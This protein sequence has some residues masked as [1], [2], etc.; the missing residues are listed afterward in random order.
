MKVV[1]AGN[2]ILSYTAALSLITEDKSVEVSIIGPRDN[3]GCASLAAAAMFNSFCEVD[4][5]TFSNR[6]DKEK[7]L[8]N[9]RAAPLWVEYIKRLEELSHVKI[10]HGFGTFLINN[11][12]TDELEDRNFDAILGALSEF[13]EPHEMVKLNSVENYRPMPNDRGSRA[14]YIPREGWVNPIDLMNSLKIILERSERVVFRDGYAKRLNFQGD[15]IQDVEL[16]CGESVSGDVFLLAAGANFSKIVD[17]SNFDVQFPRIFYGV[18]ASILLE[19]G[20]NTLKN[21]VRTP[22]RGLACG[23]YAAPQTSTKTLI[24]ASNFIS[25]IPEDGVR[26]TSLHGLVESSIRQLNSDF[27]RS[28]FVRS[29]IGWRPTSEDTVPL[30]GETSYEN[31]II[32]TGTKRDG[33]HCS[34]LIS[35]ILCNLVLGKEQGIDISLFKPEREPYKVYSREYAIKASVDNIINASYQ[36]GFKSAMNRMVEDMISYHTRELEE[37]HD[38]VGAIDWGIPP[39]MINMYRYGHATLVRNV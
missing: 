26:L 1:I 20:E 13:N 31:L 8:F 30:I 11:H 2:G 34:P 10:N 18:G 7:F 5:G 15:K 38:K 19:T 25:P 29:N 39:E 24:G 14:V 9:R 35:E 16:E 33:L 28:Q 22:N 17:A 3:K 37:L 32:A 4:V 21:C 12:S 36:H 6:F 23:L 27:Y